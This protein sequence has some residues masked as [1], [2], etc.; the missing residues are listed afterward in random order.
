MVGALYASAGCGGR[1]LSLAK[2]SIGLAGGRRSSGLARVRKSVL[3]NAIMNVSLT[4]LARY[5]TF[6]LFFPDFS[7]GRGD[8]IIRLLVAFAVGERANPGAANEGVAEI[9]VALEAGL[10]G[11][12]SERQ[13]RA[14]QQLPGA[15][16]LDPQHF[17]LG[18]PADQ[19][20][21][22][23]SSTLWDTATRFTRSFTRKPSQAWS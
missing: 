16:E 18:R 12:F 9:L 10:P 19:A 1:R 11:H 13:V 23:R 17:R 3:S 6:R 4:G 7:P 8:P 15:G 20:Q 5:P 21:E 22:F 14:G 2:A